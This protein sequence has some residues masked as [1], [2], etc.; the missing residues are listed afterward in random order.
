M[1]I[2]TMDK[3][4]PRSLLSSNFYIELMWPIQPSRLRLGAERRSG[5]VQEPDELADQRLESIGI[6]LHRVGSS[7]ALPFPTWTMRAGLDAKGNGDRDS[8]SAR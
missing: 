8:H 3:A 7:A 2:G 5:E 1:S 4:Q 6:A